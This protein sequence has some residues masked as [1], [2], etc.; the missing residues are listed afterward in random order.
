MI[1][2]IIDEEIRLYENNLRDLFSWFPYEISD[3]DTKSI[4][5]YHEK[6]PTYY[7]NEA[8][9]VF[10]EGFFGCIELNLW[11]KVEEILLKLKEEQQI[12]SFF[13]NTTSNKI[14]IDFSQE[15]PLGVY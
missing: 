9:L 14:I 12:E 2:E 5:T 11:K 10:N 3:F 8:I 6:Y 15:F 13:I 4:T 1:T 7:T